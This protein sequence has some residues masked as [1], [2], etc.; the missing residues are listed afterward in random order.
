MERKKKWLLRRRPER[1]QLGKHPLL[2]DAQALLRARKEASRAPGQRDQ[3]PR[4]NPRKPAETWE[5]SRDL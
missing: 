2:P 1:R 4:K 3:G 5:G